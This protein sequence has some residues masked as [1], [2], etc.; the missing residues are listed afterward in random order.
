MFNL[1][2]T[3]DETKLDA[4]TSHIS[5]SVPV[6]ITM[7]TIPARLKNTFRIIKHMLSK[8]SG[9]YRIILN[10]P[11]K[12]NRWPHMIINV[13]HD[14]SDRRFILNRTDDIG[15]LTKFLPSLS[16]IKDPE[17]I[18]VVCDDMCYK[19]TAFRDI[20]ERQDQ[21]RRKSFS[22]YVYPY[23]AEDITNKQVMVPQGA[24]LISMYSENIRHFPRWFEDLKIK[25]NVKNYFDSLCFF[26]DDQVIGWYMQYIGIPMIQVDEK[27]RYI[28]IENCDKTSAHNNLNAQKGRNSRDNT[29]KQCYS[30]LN[31]AFPL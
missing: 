10:V 12:Y 3:L 21:E 19:L 17:Y 26:V 18:L 20:V 2:K 14:I 6:Y 4:E 29:M 31:S 25:M 9:N 7:S 8:V 27:H 11:Y 13:S 28:Y 5:A 23:G 16:V 15:P 22:F 30:S 24:D 1:L